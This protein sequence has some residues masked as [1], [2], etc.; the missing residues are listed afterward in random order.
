MYEYMGGPRFTAR[1]KSA[2]CPRAF[3]RRNFGGTA[4]AFLRSFAM[5]FGGGI[6]VNANK[7]VAIRLIQF[8]WIPVTVTE[9]V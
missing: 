6:D 8:D 9:L 5:G 4:I 2:F 1:M 3:W 7:H